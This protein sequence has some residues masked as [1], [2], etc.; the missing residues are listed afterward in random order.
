MN[1]KMIDVFK[2]EYNG[3]QGFDGIYSLRKQNFKVLKLYECAY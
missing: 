3:I 2:I 1:P